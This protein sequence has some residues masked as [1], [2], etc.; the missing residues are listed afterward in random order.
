MRYC[1]ILLPRRF[2]P[3]VCYADRRQVCTHLFGKLARL[4]LFRMIEDANVVKRRLR[5][6]VLGRCG[7]AMHGQEQYHKNA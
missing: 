5:S 1:R 2:E 3:D 4:W 6:P 7:K